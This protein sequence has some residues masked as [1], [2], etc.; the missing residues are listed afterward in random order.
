MKRNQKINVTLA[1]ALLTTAL[2]ATSASAQTATI[3]VS[4]SWTA[5]T[6][7]SA[8]DHYVVELSVNGGTFTQVATTSTNSYTLAAASGVSHQ[9]RVAGV[10]A[11]DRQGPYSVASDAYTP[12]AGAPSAPGKPVRF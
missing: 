8:V 11:Q 1:L 12:D 4:Y 7:G 2:L 5:P 9:I 3:N 10:D 6:T